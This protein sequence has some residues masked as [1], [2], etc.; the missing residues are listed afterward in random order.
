MPVPG[1]ILAL[2]G[3]SGA[4]KSTVTRAAARAYGW[5]RL[6]EAFDRLDR[7]DLDFRTESELRWIE[8][9]LLREDARRF[10]EARRLRERGRIVVA[11]TGFLGPLTYTAGLV[12]LGI[13]PREVFDEIEALAC[14]LGRDSAYGLPDVVVYLDVP[15]TTRRRRAG[16]DARRHPSELDRRHA[17]VAR[18]ERGFYRDL[19]AQLAPGAVRFVR[20]DRPYRALVRTL[21]RIVRAS[22]TSGDGPRP[23]FDRIARG[24][25]H[26]LALAEDRTSRGRH[27]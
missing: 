13:A 23:T 16:K 4:G 7:P 27:R 11:D 19:R 18:F 12:A 17:T 26:R 24:L 5:V 25:R 2:E 10:A 3:A 21:A 20:A 14:R 22:A 15:E 1:R 6:A 8:R 9:T